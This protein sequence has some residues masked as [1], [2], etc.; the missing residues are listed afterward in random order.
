[1]KPSESK[2]SSG[3]QSD[4]K[5]SESKQSEAKQP[6]S[7]Q[8]EPSKSTIVTPPVASAAPVVPVVVAPTKHDGGDKDKSK[9][10]DSQRD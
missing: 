8:S 9:S 10:R 7:Q 3:K 4:S 6:E 5:Q 2:Q 1:M